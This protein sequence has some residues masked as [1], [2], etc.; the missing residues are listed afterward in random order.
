[1]YPSKVQSINGIKESNIDVMKTLDKIVKERGRYSKLC[2]L[3]LFPIIELLINR[4][5]Y[6]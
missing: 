3:R 4:V 6:N 2:Y 5:L 1:M